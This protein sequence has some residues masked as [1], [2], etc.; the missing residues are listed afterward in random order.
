[1]THGKKNL[2]ML[3]TGAVVAFAVAAPVAQAAPAPAPVQV[4]NQATHNSLGGDLLAIDGDKGPSARFTEGLKAH[5][6]K[7]A[8]LVNAAAH[9]SALSACIVPEDPNEGPSS[10]AES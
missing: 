1:V 3:I 2:Q 7:G 5:P 9:S 10:G 8:G 4:C 6:G